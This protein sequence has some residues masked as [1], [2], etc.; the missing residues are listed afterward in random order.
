MSTPKNRTVEARILRVNHGGEHGAIRI[1]RAQIALARLRAPDL[2]PFLTRTLAHER[3][4]LERFRA[5][6]PTRAAKPCRLMWIWSVGG[7][8]LG[9]VTGVLGRK[10]IL[11]CTEAV[12]RTVHRHLDDQLAWLGERD[13]EMAATIHD[14]QQQELG[15]LRY[16]EKERGAP[17]GLTALLDA[18]ICIAVEALIWL[19]TRGDSLR[20][21][22][23]LRA[24]A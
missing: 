19:S 9:G 14:I 21:A 7:V 16:A 4:H 3:E 10:A 18:T 20:L 23:T 15:H 17:N 5:L 1:Y 11:V 24:A 22:R 6:M 13:A 2:L 8:A 12:E